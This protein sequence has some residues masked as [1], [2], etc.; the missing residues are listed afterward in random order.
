MEAKEVQWTTL[1]SFPTQLTPETFWRII[2]CFPSSLHLPSPFIFIP[3]PFTLHLHPFIPSSSYLHPFTLPSSLHSF[4]P[5]SFHLSSFIF[6]FTPSPSFILH[7]F[8]PSS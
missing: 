5:S 6:P 4:I 8:S 2:V 1:K 7:P 3:S